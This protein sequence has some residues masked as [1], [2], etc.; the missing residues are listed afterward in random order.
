MFLLSYLVF[1]FNV[2]I[3]FLADN[4]KCFLNAFTS[5]TT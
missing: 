2:K 4:Q 3:L 1:F 5:R